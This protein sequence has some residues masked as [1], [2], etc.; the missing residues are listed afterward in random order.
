MGGKS[1]RRSVRERTNT[2]LPTTGAEIPYQPEVWN[3][4]L[5]QRSHNC[6]SY[7]LNMLE[8]ESVEKCALRQQKQQM[9]CRRIWPQP[10]VPKQ[11]RKRRH[12]RFQCNIMDPLLREQLQK[13]GF[14]AV[15]RR[16]ACPSGHYR[17]AFTVS[18]GDNYHWLRQD[19]DGYWSHKD[20]GMPTSRVDASG[21]AIVDPA[22]ADFKYANIEYDAFCG[23]YCVRNELRTDRR[24]VLTKNQ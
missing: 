10:T 20:G 12:D 11:Y 14:H 2:K 13:V 22:T 16:D 21:N 23:Y 18:S 15:S 4:P 8:S 6:F 9:S 3:T 5:V 7:A 1:A 19:P 24:S 17:V